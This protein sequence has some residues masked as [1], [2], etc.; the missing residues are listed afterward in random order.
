MKNHSIFK[1]FCIESP[2]VME[3][4]PCTPTHRKLSNDIK[5]MI[6]SILVRWISH[7]QN[8]IKQITFFHRCLV[9]LVPIAQVWTPYKIGNSTCEHSYVMYVSNFWMAKYERKLCLNWMVSFQVLS[10]SWLIFP[11]KTWFFR[12]C[13]IFQGQK[14]C[15]NHYSPHFWNQIL[16]N[17]F[18]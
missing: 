7:L 11:S 13:L 6:W 1:N 9:R 5:N 8:E 16:P 18:H 12:I 14:S 17:K 4:S 10:C 3:P 15:K 2:N